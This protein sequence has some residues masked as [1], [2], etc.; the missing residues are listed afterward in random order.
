MSISREYKCKNSNGGNPE[1][2]WMPFVDYVGSEIQYTGNYITTFPYS[3]I[4]SLS[5]PLT[6][7]NEEIDEI[8]GGVSVAQSGGFQLNKILDTDN[9]I[10]IAKIDARLIFKDSNGFYRMAGTHK[11]LKIKYT[12][13][14][15]SSIPEFNGFK[16][17][18]EGLEEKQAGFLQ[19]LSGF[20]I[21]GELSLDEILESYL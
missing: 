15:G 6:S 21:N 2:Y 4:F 1:L 9:Y 17:S 3:A 13:E 10:S 16:F 5:S 18:F 14:T 12:K 8:S 7:F 20:D 19:D 11:G